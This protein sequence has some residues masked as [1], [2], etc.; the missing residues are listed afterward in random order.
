MGKEEWDGIPLLSS[1]GFGLIGAHSPGYK[2]EERGVHLLY[3]RCKPRPNP[4]TL[5]PI[6]FCRAQNKLDARG[7]AA[8]GRSAQPGGG[9]REVE[10]G[11]GEVHLKGEGVPTSAGERQSCRRRR[12]AKVLEQHP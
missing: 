10:A 4:S 7:G 11:G 5:S 8:Q 2:P 3:P 6:C 9:G 1:V 12:S